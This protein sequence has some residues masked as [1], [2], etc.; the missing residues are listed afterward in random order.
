MA[1][2]FTTRGRIPRSVF[3]FCMVIIYAILFLLAGL[4]HAFSS[5]KEPSPL[6]GFLMLPVI[7][8]SIIVQI[9]RWHDRDKSGWWVLINFVPCIGGLWSLIECGFLRGTTGPNRFG[10]DPLEK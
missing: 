5:T 1:E 4:S 7:A 3:W 2:L 8:F 6:F 10:P 9:K